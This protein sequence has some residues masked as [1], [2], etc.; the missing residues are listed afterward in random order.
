MNLIFI[1]LFFIISIFFYFFIKNKY[2]KYIFILLFALGFGGIFYF[3]PKGSVEKKQ[4]KNSK[5]KK[6]KEH[7]LTYV[8]TNPGKKGLTQIY[9]CPKK[10]SCVVLAI[11]SPSCP[12]CHEVYGESLKNLEELA[13]KYPNIFALVKRFYPADPLAFALM[14]FCFSSLCKNSEQ[15]LYLLDTQFSQWFSEEGSGEEIKKCALDLLV[16]KNFLKPGSMAKEEE[17][18]LQNDIFS[19]YLQ[20]KKIFHIKTLPHFYVFFKKNI[21]WTVKVLHKEKADYI[22]NYFN[23][24]VKQNVIF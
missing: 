8:L 3:I 23:Y 12:V 19:L 21:P 20:D 24:L 10:A 2:L 14:T 18:K 1:L 15:S 7:I 13:K 5:E 22:L 16:K 6:P 11:V 9:G 4:K 17:K